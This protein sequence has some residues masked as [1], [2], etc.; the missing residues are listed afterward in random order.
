VAL[1]VR[2]FLLAWAIVYLLIFREYYKDKP[3]VNCRGSA[4]GIFAILTF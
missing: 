4:R 1:V 3:S 2:E